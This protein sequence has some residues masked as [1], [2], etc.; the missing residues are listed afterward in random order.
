MLEH[1]AEDDPTRF[2]EGR[3]PV[4]S[5][6]GHSGTAAHDERKAQCMVLKAGKHFSTKGNTGFLSLSWLI[7]EVFIVPA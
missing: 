2:T 5:R 6:L 7:M 4:R 3:S 1:G